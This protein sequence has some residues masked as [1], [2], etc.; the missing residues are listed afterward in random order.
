MKIL[1]RRPFVPR[2]ACPGFLNLTVHPGPSL[3]NR[4]KLN[5]RRKVSG[6][7]LVELLVVIVIIAAL[8]AVAV[9]MSQRMM[10]KARANMAMQNMHQIAPLMTT[11]AVDH[12]MKL[13]PP[14]GKVR[15]ADGSEQDMLWFEACLVELYPTVDPPQFK[16]KNWWESNKCFLRNPMFK[17]GWQPLKPGYAMNAS[18]ATN[19]ATSTGATPPTDPLGESVALSSIPDAGRAPII[20]PYI[21][22][23]YS[24]E[25]GEVAKFTK[26]PAKELLTTDGKAPILFVDG[27]VE[28]MTPKQYL[29]AKLNLYPEKEN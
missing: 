2:P 25:S 24:Y 21:D 28:I 23:T 18:L 5:M 11:Y 27:H 15:A 1:P 14:S 22:P 8:A 3:G 17:T 16:T 19:I 7:T 13:P 9:S 10:S 6:F 4:M 29:T 26:S 12:S 20:A